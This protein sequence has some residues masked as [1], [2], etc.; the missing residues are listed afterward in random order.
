MTPET[1][2]ETFKKSMSNTMKSFQDTTAIVLDAH[3]KH[4]SFMNDICTQSLHTFQ[5]I[6][7]SNSVNSFNSPEK[8]IDMIKNNFECISNL[9][10]STLKTALEFGKQASSPTISK[11]TTDNIIE[12]YT[13]QAENMVALNQK[14]FDAMTK[15]GDTDKF[16]FNSTI[17]E[18][19]K[20]DFDANVELSKEQLHSIIDSYNK[21]TNPS[22]ESNKSFLN[23]I[24]KQ[25][26]T[27]FDAN[28]KLWSELMGTTAQKNSEPEPNH[29]N[30]NFNKKGRTESKLQTN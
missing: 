12:T 16:F 24:S 11:Q 21:V 27:M 23:N 17:M 18:K 8:V 10:K 6:N 29:M 2:A 25:I 5:D 3:A 13:K 28:L 22:F 14:F 4:L 30:G 20:K 7:K 19:S 15:Q 9:S 26:D 1:F